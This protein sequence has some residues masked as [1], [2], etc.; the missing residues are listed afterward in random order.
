LWNV[1]TTHPTKEIGR[2]VAVFWATDMLQTTTAAACGR[3]G[4]F[5]VAAAAV[6]VLA[7][8]RVST[9]N[10]NVVV[11]VVIVVVKRL[12]RSMTHLSKG[13]F[14]RICCYQGMIGHQVHY[15]RKMSKL[16]MK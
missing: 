6:V 1:Q 15:T 13:L 2:I 16:V 10:H 7:V 8:V 11:S 5:L 4:S 9:P 14:V 12:E 3:G